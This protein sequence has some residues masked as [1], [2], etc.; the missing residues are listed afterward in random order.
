MS[1]VYALLDETNTTVVEYPLTIYQ[2]RGMFTNISWPDEPNEE[3]LATYHLVIVARVDPPVERTG[4]DIVEGTPMIVDG[5][6]T[7]VWT[8]VSQGCYGELKPD[9]SDVLFYPLTLKQLKA[10]FPNVEWPNIPTQALLEA[11]N[12]V[13]VD[14]DEHP[15]QFRRGFHLCEGLPENRNGRWK[16][17]WTYVKKHGVR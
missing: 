2:I 12:L 10:K 7:Q 16:Q 4:Y 5:V 9:K 15:R 3:A 1:I 17:V 6:W 11:H 8:Y 14:L 13:E